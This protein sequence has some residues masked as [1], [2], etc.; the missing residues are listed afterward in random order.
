MMG[1]GTVAVL[2]GGGRFLNPP[3]LLFFFLQADAVVGSVQRSGKCRRKL[4]G[5][6]EQ[7]VTMPALAW[8]Q[9]RMG[10]QVAITVQS[11]DRGCLRIC[12][13]P[14]TIASEG[15]CGDGMRGLVR[16]R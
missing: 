16:K 15:A 12:D 5:V 6:G 8:S 9:W 13:G 10:D 7:K 4:D 2:G 14:I 11:R 1:E 3:V